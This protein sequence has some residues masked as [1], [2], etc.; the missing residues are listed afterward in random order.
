M[1]HSKHVRYIQHFWI[2]KLLRSL[3]RWYTWSGC[4]ESMVIDFTI[5]HQC[6]CISWW[7]WC[8]SHIYFFQHGKVDCYSNHLQRYSLSWGYRCWSSCFCS[9]LLPICFQYSILS[10]WYKESRPKISQNSWRTKWRVEKKSKPTYKKKSWK[11][12]Q[13]W[14]N[15]WHASAKWKRWKSIW[16]DWSRRERRLYKKFDWINA[17]W[18]NWGGQGRNLVIRIK[19]SPLQNFSLNQTTRG[20]CY[21]IGQIDLKIG[22]I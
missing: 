8:Q 11:L 9:C 21:R 16:K 18:W 15:P 4:Y 3:R 2:G 22:W 17:K 14:G 13:A 10:T 6:P 5:W 19:L 1:E 7:M 12:R 20:S